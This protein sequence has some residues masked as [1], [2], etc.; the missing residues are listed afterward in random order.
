MKFFEKKKKKLERDRKIAKMWYQF[1]YRSGY[2][3]GKWDCQMSNE[4]D[5]TQ[6]SMKCDGKF[7]ETW[8]WF[9][10]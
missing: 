1:G 3:E 2:L 6:V 4:P 8:E 7:K 9:G 5:A 10:K